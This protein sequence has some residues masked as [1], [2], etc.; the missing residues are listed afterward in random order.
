[1][2]DLNVRQ[3]FLAEIGQIYIIISFKKHI[4]VR[5]VLVL[6]LLYCKVKVIHYIYGMKLN[7]NI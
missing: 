4:I 6:I 3:G 7:T 5:I 2:W 1:M